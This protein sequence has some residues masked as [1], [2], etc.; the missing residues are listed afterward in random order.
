VNVNLVDFL[1]GQKPYF[2]V[3]RGCVHQREGWCLAHKDFEENPDYVSDVL[4]EDVLA[5]IEYLATNEENLRV[6]VY[7]VHM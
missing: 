2:T 4:A 7:D 5:E 1:T 6:W 3:I